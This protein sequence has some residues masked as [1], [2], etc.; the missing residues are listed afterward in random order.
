MTEKNMP[1]RGW[2]ASGGKKKILIIED[3][4]ALQKSLKSSLEEV[5]FEVSQLF[6]G[7]NGAGFMR[8]R[9]PDLILLDLMLPDQDGFHL[10]KDIK[11]DK[12]LKDIKVLVLS[13]IDSESSIQE[14]K[15]LGADDYL[16]KSDHSLDEIVKKVKQYLK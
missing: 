5:G 6:G 1:A 13:V 8:A 2:F 4:N 11:S 15:M 9:K 16:I 10:L 3:N 12:D 14:C 7:G